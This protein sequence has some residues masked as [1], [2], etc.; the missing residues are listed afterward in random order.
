MLYKT[1]YGV[2]KHIWGVGTGGLQ[3][4]RGRYLYGNVE[5]VTRFHR[6]IRGEDALA[7]LGAEYGL[8][9]IELSH[10]LFDKATYY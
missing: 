4:L 8:R 7:G 2:S 3:F 5:T 9:T 10:E 1:I 6:S